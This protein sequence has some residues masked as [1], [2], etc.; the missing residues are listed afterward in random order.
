MGGGAAV[1]VC[2]VLLGV[3]HSVVLLVERSLVLIK[4]KEKITHEQ[5][6][7]VTPP[8]PAACLSFGPPQSP[9]FLCR[10]VAALVT[11]AT[12]VSSWWWFFL[13]L[14]CLVS[15]S[16]HRGSRYYSIGSVCL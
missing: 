11:I 10:L 9:S 1:V 14:L 2:S 12:L 7:E 13:L 4:L 16:C 6:Q 3:G 8:G 5:D 15:T